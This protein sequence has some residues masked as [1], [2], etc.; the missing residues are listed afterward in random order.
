MHLGHVLNMRQSN[1]LE[2]GCAGYCIHWAAGEGGGGSQA[3]SAS[4]P[5]LG[6]WTVERSARCWV[7]SIYGMT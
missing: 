4:F 6:A 5:L 3:S 2:G 7:S 1:W